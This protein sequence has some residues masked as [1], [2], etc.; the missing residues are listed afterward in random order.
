MKVLS[1]LDRATGEKRSMV[2]DS[3]TIAEITPILRANIAAEAHFLT[4]EAG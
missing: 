2:V 1:L 3:I 4:D